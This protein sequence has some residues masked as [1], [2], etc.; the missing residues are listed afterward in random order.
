M[1]QSIDIRASLKA[2]FERD[3]ELASKLQKATGPDQVKALI[4]QSAQHHEVTLDATGLEQHLGT[5][6]RQAE[7]LSQLQALMETDPTLEPALRQATEAEAVRG[8]IM[9]SAQRHGKE[10]DADELLALFQNIPV[11]GELSDQALEDVTGGVVGVGTLVVIGA[12]YALALGA[13]AGLGI[14]GVMLGYTVMKDTS[15]R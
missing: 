2:L 5:L 3:S 11:Q 4:M 14:L 13:G 7:M 9:A 12:T 15:K 6:A 8:L 10:L 1:T